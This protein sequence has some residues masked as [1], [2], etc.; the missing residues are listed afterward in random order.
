MDKQ[1]K[2]YVA[3]KLQALGK[4]ESITNAINCTGFATKTGVDLDD[5]TL[6]SL[7]AGEDM[8]CL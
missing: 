5:T 1:Q 7:I 4:I 6:T 2:K 3:P 8:S